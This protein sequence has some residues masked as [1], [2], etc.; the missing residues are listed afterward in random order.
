MTR[1]LAQ[2]SLL[3][4][5]GSYVGRGS[6]RREEKIPVQVGATQT[7][8]RIQTSSRRASSA[9]LRYQSSGRAEPS[10]VEP[11]RRRASQRENVKMDRPANRRTDQRVDGQTS[12][13]PYKRLR[14]RLR[15]RGLPLDVVTPKMHHALQ[16]GLPHALACDP[17]SSNRMPTFFG[18]DRRR[19]H[20]SG[21]SIY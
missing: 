15:Q 13:V 4:R 17:V 10:R 19:T 5:N 7:T 11:S 6:A 12:R 20:P 21:V 1:S 2:G 9:T 3:L 14:L 18:D 16:R 8:R